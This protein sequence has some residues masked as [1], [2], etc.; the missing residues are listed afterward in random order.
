MR[1]IH[2]SDLMLKAAP[3]SQSPAAGMRRD[4]RRVYQLGPAG[5][6]PDGTGG[7]MQL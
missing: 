2:W 4:D 1:R 3:R 5:R 6:L 7:H